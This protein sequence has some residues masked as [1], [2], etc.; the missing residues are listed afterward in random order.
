V[1]DEYKLVQHANPFGIP[2]LAFTPFCVLFF[3]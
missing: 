1:L 2:V 3:I